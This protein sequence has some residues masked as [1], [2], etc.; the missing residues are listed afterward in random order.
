[1]IDIYFTLKF[2]SIVEDLAIKPGIANQLLAYTLGNKA[3]MRNKL[4]LKGGCWE[5]KI[6]DIK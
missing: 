3:G 1:M 2:P 6:L 5:P 4:K